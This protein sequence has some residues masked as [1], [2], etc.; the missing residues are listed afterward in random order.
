MVGNLE[1]RHGRG[2]GA[3]RLVALLVS[4]AYSEPTQKEFFSA[5]F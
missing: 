4:R 2:V 1:R 3:T 5:K